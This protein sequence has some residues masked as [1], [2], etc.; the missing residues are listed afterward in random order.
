MRNYK[1]IPH[2]DEIKAFNEYLKENNEVVYQNRH[3][4]VIKNRYIK[5][6][7]VAF[8]KTKRHFITD[9]T[10]SE[11]TSLAPIIKKY[12]HNHIYINSAQEKSLPNRLHIHIK[13]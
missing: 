10:P 13:L 7:L 1:N 4:L 12:K 2:P 9:C 3:W 8:I 6:Q 11:L 5:K